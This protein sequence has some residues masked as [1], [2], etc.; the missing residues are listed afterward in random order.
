MKKPSLLLFSFVI[1]YLVFLYAPIMLL[2]IFA[3]NDSSIIAFPLSG[4]TVDWFVGLMGEN[5]LHRALK[6]SLIIAITAAVI[7][8][9]FGILT[10]RAMARHNFLGKR[11]SFG[12]IMAPLFLPEIII[13]VAL[14]IV[15]I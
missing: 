2:P 4:F 11:P 7:S 5:T 12:L 14:L 1:I 6:N 8:T 13:G 15:L 9:C 3:F 10:A